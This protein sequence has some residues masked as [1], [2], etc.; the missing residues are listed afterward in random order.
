MKDPFYPRL[1][2]RD[3]AQEAHDRRINDIAAR[4]TRGLQSLDHVEPEPGSVDLYDLLR[5]APVVADVSGGDPFLTRHGL[6][7]D[8]KV[9]TRSL[10]VWVARSWD[11]AWKKGRHILY[12]IHACEPCESSLRWQFV[13]ACAVPPSLT[14][15][16]WRELLAAHSAQPH[17]A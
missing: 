4:I 5:A 17:A 8:L 3:P 1:R 7:Y 2:L 9:S 14:E 13:P 15:P 11:R 6:S 12:E 16:A 10:R